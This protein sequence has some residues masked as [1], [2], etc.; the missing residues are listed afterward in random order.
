LPTGKF[1]D[2]DLGLVDTALID[3]SRTVD[4]AGWVVLLDAKH[5]IHGPVLS[6]AVHGDG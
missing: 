5:R 4:L 3:G 6:V 2:V 1:G